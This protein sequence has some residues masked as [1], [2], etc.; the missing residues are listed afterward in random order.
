MTPLPHL[1]LI[2]PLPSDADVI[3]GTKVAF[4]GLV[5]ELRA[6]GRFQIEVHDTTR[7]RAGRGALRRRLDD[8][9]QLGGLVRRLL[10]AGRRPDGVMFNTSPGGLLLAGPLV[11]A[12]CRAKG[13]PLA[14]RVFGG[15]LDRHIERAISPIR[16]LAR[17]TFLRSDL[18]LLETRALCT[19][20]AGEGARRWPN[21][22]DLRPR[23]T[24][25]RPR[26][27]RFLFLG[28]LRREKG[29]GEAVRA[30]ASLPPGASL[31]IHGPAM[32]GFDLEPLLAGSA[33]RYEGPLGPEEVPRVLEQHDVLVFPSYHSGEGMP[34]IL[35]EAFQLGLP[36]IAADWRAVPELVEHEANGLLVA[37][38]DAEGLAAAMR[39][40][41]EDPM[42]FRRLSIG[43]RATGEEYRSS[44]WNA[45]MVAWL[46]ELCGV[47]V[48]ETVRPR[49]LEEAA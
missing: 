49:P 17:A 10:R 38:R 27:T 24:G 36:V 31:T 48:R 34:G 40:L 2:G 6:S 44:R 14:V 5:E 9:L 13:T 16:R 22:R 1:L 26:A 8:L 19:R 35:V 46:E 30:A 25:L 42:L 7:P 28:Q 21:T 37:P 43:A 23:A 20:L 18:L 15:D 12:L 11:W 32:P 39:R 41:S 4:A 3:G 33:C 45:R 29:A 47:P